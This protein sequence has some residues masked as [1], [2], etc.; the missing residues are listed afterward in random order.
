MYVQTILKRAWPYASDHKF[1]LRPD[2]YL[3]CT[4]SLF[5]GAREGVFALSCAEQYA[6]A[7][8]E[9]RTQLFRKRMSSRKRM[10]DGLAVALEVVDVGDHVHGVF[11]DVDGSP[12]NGQ[13]E[14]M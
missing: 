1:H 2:S 9:H 10:S 12:M 7:H 11:A 8:N 4:H 14:T 3:L 5:S 13:R 6:D